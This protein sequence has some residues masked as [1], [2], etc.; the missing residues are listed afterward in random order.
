[1]STKEACPI[2]GESG[3]LDPSECSFCADQAFICPVCGATAGEPHGVSQ[4]PETGV[5]AV[6][7]GR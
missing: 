5:W 3:Y 7:C 6:T 4:D 1:M 2:C